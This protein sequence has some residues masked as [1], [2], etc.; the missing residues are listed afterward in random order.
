MNLIDIA[1]WQQG[2]DLATMF[3]KNASLGGVIVKLTQGTGYVNPEA[4]GWLDWL[5]ANAKPFGTYHYLDGGGA[6][7]EAKHY[8]DMLKVYPGGVPALDYEEQAVLKL[9]TAYLKE[10]LDE[11]YRLTGV[12]PLVYCSQSV[13]QSQDFKA[14]AAA[15][16]KLWVAQYADMNPVIGFLD[17]PW[18]R[19]SV[20]PFDGYVMQ[21]YTS[22]GKLDGWGMRLDFDKFNGSTADWAKLAGGSA[23][24]G[25]PSTKLKGPDPQ[26]VADVLDGKYGTGTDRAAALK[27]AGYNAD[28]VQK[29]V[30]ELYALALTFRKKLVGNEQYTDCVCQIMEVL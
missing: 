1:S 3:R 29:K 28:K 27:A 11:V 9:G 5:I 24:P 15:G 4:K 18:Q 26:V 16:Y 25:K 22:C 6:K 21:Q 10:C 2:M 30:N 13:T 14:I 20:A 19:G 17:T 8:A 7:A 12:K 23:E